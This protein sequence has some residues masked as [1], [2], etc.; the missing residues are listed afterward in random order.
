MASISAPYG[1]HIDQR[2]NVRFCKAGSVVPLTRIPVDENGLASAHDIEQRILDTFDIRG[3]IPACFTTQLMDYR[4]IAAIRSA[5]DARW[6]STVAALT[7]DFALNELKNV[8]EDVHILSLHHEGR[9]LSL[10]LFE[11]GDGILEVLHERATVVEPFESLT[12]ALLRTI[13]DFKSWLSHDKK[14]ALLYLSDDNSMRQQLKDAFALL[15]AEDTYLKATLYLAERDVEAPARG[16][17]LH[18]QALYADLGDNN[19]LL[20]DAQPFEVNLVFGKHRL[21]FIAASTTV[22]TTHRERISL[23]DNEHLFLELSSYCEQGLRQSYPLDIDGSCRE[24][25][26]AERAGLE[27][28]VDVDAHNDIRVTLK[29][30]GWSKTIDLKAS[31]QPDSSP[32]PATPQPAGGASATPDLTPPEGLME[33]IK[34]LD[35]VDQGVRAV[36]QLG[37]RQTAAGKGLAAL[38]ANLLDSIA[39]LG[40]E[41]YPALGTTF[42]PHLHEAFGV[43]AN[44]S[45]PANAVAEELRRG[46]IYQGRVIRYSLV[47][48]ANP[49]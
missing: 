42:D 20:L 10:A 34:L 22:P 31:L 32:I 2:G 28:T 37:E 17:A 46:F 26:T 13:R 15:Q 35:D 8:K 12:D 44:P 6:I 29:T 5:A 36:D 24:R 7:I 25:L 18:S 27:V 45:L 33:L 23:P 3:H 40:G 48:V 38:Q 21:P 39:K 49:L 30:E 1:I 11:R 14:L 47:R 4:A 19:Y 41:Y 43:V 9:Q 16:A